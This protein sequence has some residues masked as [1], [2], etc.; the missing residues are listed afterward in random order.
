MID[1]VLTINGERVE[2]SIDPRL[3]LAD[4]LRE[5]LHLTGTHIG[6]EHGVC[7]ACT[8]HL[9]GVSARS[10]I[11]LAAA[12]DGHDVKTIEGFEDDS[13]MS[14][15]R[16]EFSREHALQCGYCSPG[17]L[18]TSY[19]LVTRFPGLDE[20]D[21]RREMSGNLCRCTGYQ[22]IVRALQ[23]VYAMNQQQD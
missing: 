8:I 23:N 5:K 11:T 13:T 7:G 20:A 3:S 18:M 16:T 1:I 19:D 15:I 10:C 17:M 21:I 6:C 12:C 14:A 4:F 2:A 9:D 22:G